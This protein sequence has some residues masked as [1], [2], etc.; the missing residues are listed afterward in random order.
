MDCVTS[1]RK[2]VLGNGCNTNF[3][4][5]YWCVPPIVNLI[6]DHDAINTNTLVSDFLYN[7]SWNFPTNITNLTPNFFYG[8]LG[9]YYFG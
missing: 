9:Y 2:I 6:Q 1:N 8:W 4:L 5:D 7:G 3:W